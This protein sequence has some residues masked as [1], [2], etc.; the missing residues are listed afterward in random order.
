MIRITL[1]NCEEPVEILNIGPLSEEAAK[2]K[3]PVKWSMKRHLQLEKF[4]VDALAYC[5][6]VRQEQPSLHRTIISQALEADLILLA[7][8]GATEL[9][10]SGYVK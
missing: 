9:R 2:A 8:G 6:T 7:A 10:V 4:V 3:N 5:S 1:E